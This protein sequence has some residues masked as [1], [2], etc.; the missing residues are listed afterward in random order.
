MLPRSYTPR[1]SRPR[2]N[3]GI[4][5]LATRNGAE[6]SHGFGELTL[7]A[8]NARLAPAHTPFFD[9]AERERGGGGGANGG[10]GGGT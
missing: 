1:I 10:V 9:S 3:S 2:K 7:Q 6:L 5:H 4:T 8:G